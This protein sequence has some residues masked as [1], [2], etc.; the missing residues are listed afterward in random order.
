MK[1]KTKIRL[2]LI[3][4]LAIIM[5]LAITGSIYVNKLADISSAISKDNYESLEYAKNMIRALDEDDS[6]I[7]VKSFEEN[8]VNEEH[9]ITEA[10]EKDAAHDLRE[11]FELYKSGQRDDRT[12]T[13]LRQKVLYV[14]DLNMNAIVRKNDVATKTTKRVFAY[15][16]ILGTLSFLLSFTFVINFPGL[17]ANPVAELTTGIREIANRNYASRINFKANDEFGQV[18]EAFNEMARRLDDYEHSNLSKLMFEKKRIEA[19]INNMRDA[20]VGLDEKNKVL[21]TNTVALQLLGLNETDL[22]GKYAPDVALRNDLLRNLLVKEEK[23]K[24]LK[25][26]ADKKESYFNKDFLEIFNGDQKIGEVIILR[27]IT[28]FQELDLAKTNFIATI[29]HELKTPIS[30][31]NMSLKLLDDQRIGDMNTEQKKLVENIKADSQRLLKIT[32]ELLDL[33]QVESGNINLNTRHVSP[34]DIISQASN[35]VQSLAEQKS[36]TIEK[37]IAANLPLVKADTEKTSWVLL[38]FLTNAV[39]YSLPGSKIIIAAR[40]KEG[41]V[42]FSVKDYGR[43]IEEK[44]LGK[45][46]DKFFQVPGSASDGTGMGLAISKE[47]IEKQ[48]GKIGVES[49]PNE[50]STFTFSLSA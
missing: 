5:A 27:N 44:Y 12:K 49:K 50:G 31:I 47:I 20:I 26:Y 8:L 40:Q 37:H 19:I 30:S 3:F 18:A 28:R 32:S 9:N 24:L 7:S 21:F 48:G 10:G 25:I 35:A 2:G 13:L 36:I 1:I 15:I 42:E 22:I 14:Q 39:R 38:N 45:I 23:D 17:I 6:A 46:F 16:T 33:T 4:L 43:G 11:V 29:S 34:L 41:N